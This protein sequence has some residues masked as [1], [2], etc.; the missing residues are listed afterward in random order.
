MSAMHHHDGD[1]EEID[2]QVNRLAL[3]CGVS[4][5]KPGVIEAIFHSDTSVCHHNNPMAWEKLRGLLILRYHVV[6]KNAGEEGAM[7]G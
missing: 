6:V 5:D 4:L 7:G 1:L 3:L 2:Q